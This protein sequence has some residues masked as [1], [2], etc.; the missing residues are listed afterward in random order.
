MRPC[1]GALPGGKYSDELFARTGRRTVPYLIDEGKAVEMF[2]SSPATVGA[3]LRPA[4]SSKE[5]ETRTTRLPARLPAQSPMTSSTTSTSTTARRRRA[6][7]PPKRAS[8]RQ[9][10]QM[11]LPSSRAPCRGSW[12][13]RRCKA[14]C[15][16]WPL[17]PWKSSSSWLRACA[18]ATRAPASIWILSRGRYAAVTGASDH[19]M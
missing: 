17:R 18:D 6:R 13:R 1:P 12:R 7:S 15:S 9:Q 8:T 14:N 16:W 19:M 10:M 3:M 11:R 5:T 2:G 4:L